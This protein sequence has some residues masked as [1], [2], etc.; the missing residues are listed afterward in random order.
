MV[1]RIL[2]FVALLCT[3]AHTEAQQECT[4]SHETLEIASTTLMETR[5]INVYLPPDYESS[6]EATYPVLYML[7]GGVRE[8]F[9]HVASAIDRAIREEAIASIILVG[10]ENTQR[11]RDMTG[12][13]TVE[14]DQ[15][16]APNVGESAKFRGFI[17][18][19]LFPVIDAR[20]RTKKRTR[21]IIGESLAGL[22]VIET[23]VLD[24]S[25]FDTYIA[26]SPSLWWNQG[27][28]L[29]L[30]PAG[31]AKGTKASIYIASADEGN[32]APL[33]QE[34]RRTILGRAPAHLDWRIEEYPTLTHSTIYRAL[35]PTVLR[36]H[37]P[38]DH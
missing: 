30:I 3:S 13:T 37:Y 31:L 12:P 1:L 24:Q 18:L 32:I 14:S 33:L 38:P 22:F 6:P 35:T 27:E 10:I 5:T 11:R 15:A 26:L 17:Q 20:Y 29:K 34:I 36:K 9:P 8:D 2:F 28:L 4:P 7:D 16:I 23:F 25:M 21:G 19:E